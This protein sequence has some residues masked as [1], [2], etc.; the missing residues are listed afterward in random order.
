MTA[1]LKKLKVINFLILSHA[2]QIILLGTLLFFCDE[3]LECLLANFGSQC[4]IPAH[5][6]GF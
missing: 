6:V 1:F 2:E 3:P 4:D 5:M